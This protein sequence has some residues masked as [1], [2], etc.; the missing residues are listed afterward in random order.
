MTQTT[1]CLDREATGS[2]KGH[3]E[4]VLPN[5]RL[6]LTRAA[7]QA[8]RASRSL[9]AAA[10]RYMLWEPILATAAAALLSEGRVRVACVDVL[11]LQGA[12]RPLTKF[13]G[14][15]QWQLVDIIS[16][17]FTTRWPK[18]GTA[19]LIGGLLAALALLLSRL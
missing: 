1:C 5:Q 17:P 8:F 2:K 19:L 9:Q 4:I 14:L 15:V 3:Q 18:W 10:A 6:K 12:A 16:I 11:S 13:A 7:L